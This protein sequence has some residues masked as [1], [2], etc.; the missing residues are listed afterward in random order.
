MKNLF[1]MNKNAVDSENT[2]LEILISYLHK[3]YKVK[4]NNFATTQ[5]YIFKQNLMDT[6]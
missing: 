1:L 2:L 4:K 3:K 5:P 6:Y